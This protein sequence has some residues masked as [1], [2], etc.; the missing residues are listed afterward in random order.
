MKFVVK[1]GCIFFTLLLLFLVAMG[2]V[3]IIEIF[4]T[5]LVGWLYFLKKVLDYITLN[6]LLII[7]GIL[8]LLILTIGI[9]WFCSWFY[10]NYHQQQSRWS[11]KWSI[12]GVS[13]FI[14][15]FI[16]SICFTGLVHEVGWLTTTPTPTLQSDS[17]WLRSE[18]KESST[19]RILTAIGEELKSYQQAYNHLPVTLETI[20]QQPLTYAWGMPIVYN[21]NRQSFVLRSYG[22]NGILGSGTGKF[23]DIV[24]F[25]DL[26]TIIQGEKGY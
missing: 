16:I 5:L 14:L 12:T 10:A 2:G 19:T 23:D 26:D 7:E 20:S 25:S 6:P 21:T 9:H 24:Y 17:K 15:M 3:F 13:F 22:P 4:W 18:Y 1:V 11:W 8:T